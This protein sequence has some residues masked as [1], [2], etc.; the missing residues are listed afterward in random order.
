[1][2]FPPKVS[3]NSLSG[4]PQIVGEDIDITNVEVTFGIDSEDFEIRYD[5]LF[6]DSN[7]R[8]SAM[9]VAKHYIGYTS[10]KEIGLTVTVS[11]D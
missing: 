4:N 3:L 6:D 9:V 11:F 7:K 1:M 5:S 10:T 2:P 8:H